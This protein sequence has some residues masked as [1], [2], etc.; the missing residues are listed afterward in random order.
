M[1]LFDAEAQRRRGA[2]WFFEESIPLSRVF[3]H[4]EVPPVGDIVI[5]RTG[6]DN[7]FLCVSAPLGRNTFPC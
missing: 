2:K 6:V 1:T 7:N 4:A 5:R 3:R